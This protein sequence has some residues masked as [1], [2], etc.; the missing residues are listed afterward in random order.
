MTETSRPWAGTTT[1]DAG[2][3]TDAQWRTN[4][5]YI[6]QHGTEANFGPLLDVL[7]ELVVGATSPTSK[8]VEVETG[9]A[10][11]Q[12]G[13]YINDLAETLTISDNGSGQD[14]IDLVVLEVDYSAQ[15]IRLVVEAG[16]PAASPVAPSPTQTAGVLWQVPLA[17]VDADNGFAS[18]VAADIRDRREFV[19]LPSH[20]AATLNNDAGAALDIGDVVKVDTGA[21]TAVDTTTLASDPRIVGALV[22]GN[23]D[24]EAVRLASLGRTRL[25]VDGAASRGAFLASDTV[26][27]Q[28]TP[29]TPGAFAMLLE[30]LGGAGYGEALL[31]PRP[32]PAYA[33]YEKDGGDY[34]T[35]STSFTPVDSTNMSFTLA[36]RG[37][38]V[39]IGLLGSTLN[40][41]YDLFTWF[42]VEVDGARIGDS[43]YGLLQ[44]ES[45]R[46][47][48]IWENASFS[49]LLTGL[50]PG[51]HTFRLVWRVEGGTAYLGG[52][53][54]YP[55][56]EFFVV[57]I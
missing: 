32:I 22:Q 31:L 14:R 38:P 6:A 41:T 40:S 42:D 53:S 47:S 48:G 56:S 44:V 50:S 19:N 29:A 25:Y 34:S 1:G 24:G 43:N 9:A 45:K 3:Y 26:A 46:A 12:G 10:I 11:V 36:I 35:A 37:G 15:T 5:Q 49:Y 7:N 20:S 17:E 27:G 8:A 55:V 23:A 51:S 52:G 39:L 13:I 30:T 16:V 33:A 4:F 54:S 2:P 21:D 57:E 18:I 28:V